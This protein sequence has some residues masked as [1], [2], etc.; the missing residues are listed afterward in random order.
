MRHALTLLLLATLAGCGGPAQD[1]IAAACPVS[2]DCG[3]PDSGDPAYVQCHQRAPLPNLPDGGHTCGENGAFL[4]APMCTY[5]TG[6]TLGCELHVPPTCFCED[7]P[8]YQCPAPVPDQG[9]GTTCLPRDGG[10]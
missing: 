5:C 8:C 6:V 2:P 3:T 9:A 4:R 7:I 1:D 10:R